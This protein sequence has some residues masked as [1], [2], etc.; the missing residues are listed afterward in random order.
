MLNS[1]L[2][3]LICTTSNVNPHNSR[4]FCSKRFIVSLFILLSTT[5]WS[6]LRQCLLCAYQRV[7]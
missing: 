1:A 6:A 2:A 4:Y 7:K 5:N 3:G